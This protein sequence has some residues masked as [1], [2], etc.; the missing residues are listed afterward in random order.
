MDDLLK[1]NH[2]CLKQKDRIIKSSYQSFYL[3]KTTFTKDGFHLK[4]TG[5]T[6]NIYTIIVENFKFYCDCPDNQF[7]SKNNLYCKHICFV[8][9][10]IGNINDINIFINKVL[11]S[12][13]YDNIVSRLKV[14]CSDDPNI[15]NSY[16]IQKFKKVNSNITARN[17]EDDCPICFL[18]LK[19]NENETCYNCLN[20]IHKDCN[21][22]WIEY[23]TTCVFCRNDTWNNTK[24]IFT[25]DG[26]LNIS[27]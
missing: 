12:S 13:Q 27:R 11:T 8:I 18:S 5:S 22:R 7:C 10:F 1:T 3:L 14:N 19:Q 2:I 16:L 26:Y 9:Y 4:I 17:L 15:I 20:A 6:L 23:N 21:K 25:V 24:N